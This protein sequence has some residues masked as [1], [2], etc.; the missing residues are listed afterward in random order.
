MVNV[1]GERPLICVRAS[2]AHSEISLGPHRIGIGVAIGTFEIEDLLVGPRCKQH[3]HLARSYE[4]A[5]TTTVTVGVP[6][7]AFILT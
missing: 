3:S 1:D 7:L 2:G 4:S 6:P 5:N